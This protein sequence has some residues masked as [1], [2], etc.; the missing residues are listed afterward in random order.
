MTRHTLW[1]G[2]AG[3]G[4][5]L[6]MHTT[7]GVPSLG[8]LIPLALLLGLFIAAT[9]WTFRRWGQTPQTVDGLSGSETLEPA[10]TK[11]PRY[12]FEPG[13][14]RRGAASVIAPPGVVST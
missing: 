8:E 4:G 1:C 2:G 12:G 6:P 5:G 13:R 3:A 7:V 10:E 9:V 11:A 14:E